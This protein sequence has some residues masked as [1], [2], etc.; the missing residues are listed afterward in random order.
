MNGSRF[1]DYPPAPFIGESR[2][3]IGAFLPFTWFLSSAE[4]PLGSVR[5][6]EG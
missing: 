2:T 5:D 1:V 4:Q 6:Q 3:F